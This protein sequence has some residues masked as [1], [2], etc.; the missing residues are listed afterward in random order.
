[1]Y[2]ERLGHFQSL[3]IDQQQLVGYAF[4]TNSPLDAAN[5]PRRATVDGQG[6]YFHS[7]LYEA[8]ARRHP[9]STT[10]SQGV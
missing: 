4:R 9:V 2:Y 6:V 10:G 3:S 7:A 1:M 5:I 8:V